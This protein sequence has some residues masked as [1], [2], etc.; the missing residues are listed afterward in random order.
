MKQIISLL[1]G[2]K[3]TRK[4]LADW[5]HEWRKSVSRDLAEKDKIIIDGSRSQ[6]SPFSR[7]WKWIIVQ[8]LLWLIIS[9]KFDFPPVINLMAFFTILNQFIN[10]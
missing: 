8:A 2:P 7:Q 9:F 10:K 6:V 1:Y 3:Y 4:Q 5:F